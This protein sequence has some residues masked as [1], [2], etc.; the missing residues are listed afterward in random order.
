[1][2]KD[3][4]GG[5]I[6]NAPE[7]AKKIGAT[8]FALFTKNQRQWKAKPLTNKSIN[9]FKSR[10]REFGYP[11]ESILAHDSYLINLG[12]P[13]REKRQ[14]SLDAFVDEMERC[15]Q[16]GLTALNFH[17]GSHLKQISEPLCLD[18]ISDSINKAI[19]RVPTV[20]AVIENTAGQGSN[21][22]FR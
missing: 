14:K 22:G 19:D 10:C 6:E 15:N 18:L 13:D 8:A 1:M 12:H 11:S 5:G 17:P 2:K 3:G 21:L 20:K 7:N 9:L 4:T 16:L